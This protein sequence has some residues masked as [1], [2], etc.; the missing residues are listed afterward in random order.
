MNR[1]VLCCAALLMCAPAVAQ[2]PGSGLGEETGRPVPRFVSLGAD[3]VNMRLGPGY[4]YNIIWVYQKHGL[5][6]EIIREFKR[7][8]Q[9]RVF[10]GETGWIRGNLL[11]G[12]RTV[13][14]IGRQRTMHADPSASSR[15][16]ARV[17]SGVVARLEE[18]EPDWCLIKVDGYEGWINRSYVWGSSTEA[19]GGG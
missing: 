7:W 17:E 8:R 2:N 1:L 5:P 13:L 16:V 3:K 15:P 4:D 19:I 12:R 6:V 10:S 11:S 18:C 14:V 9:V